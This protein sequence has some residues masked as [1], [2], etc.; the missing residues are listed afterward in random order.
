MFSDPVEW[1]RSIGPNVRAIRSEAGYE[2]V[3]EQVKAAEHYSLGQSLERPLGIMERGSGQADEFMAPLTKHVPL[4]A[5]SERGYLGF[6]NA[7]RQ[8]AFDKNVNALIRDFGQLEKVPIAE[9]QR[10]ADNINN[11]SMY[12]NL[13]ALG[14]STRMIGQTFFSARG[15][16]SSSLTSYVRW[17]RRHRRRCERSSHGAR[18][19]TWGPA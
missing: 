14:D 12:G 15:L 18:L 10:A 5:A 1:W 7:L 19:P 16:A 8:G 3:M 13:S 2:G 6:L 11:A 9:I 4:L 17:G